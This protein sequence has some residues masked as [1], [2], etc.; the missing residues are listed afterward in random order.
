MEKGVVCTVAAAA[1]A[2]T[3]ATTKAVG[4]FEVVQAVSGQVD[5]MAV[6]AMWIAGHRREMEVEAL[7]VEAS[8]S[9]SP[10]ARCSVAIAPHCCTTW[11]VG[12]K[13]PGAIYSL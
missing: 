7:L 3:V 5:K 4:V 13:A 1:K 9:W 6:V 11:F 2:V 12:R 8:V 10:P